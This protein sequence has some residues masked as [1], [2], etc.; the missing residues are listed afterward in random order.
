MAAQQDLAAQQEW[1]ASWTLV[2]GERDHH[3]RETPSALVS[4]GEKGQATQPHI[5]QV[6]HGSVLRCEG[7]RDLSAPTGSGFCCLN[8]AS[9]SQEVFAQ[10]RESVNRDLAAKNSGKLRV[11]NCQAGVV[12]GKFV[13][14]AYL[15]K[16]YPG[17]GQQARAMGAT[18]HGWTQACSSLGTSEGRTNPS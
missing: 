7:L 3:G 15:F 5:P 13:Y 2:E 18:M 14:K 10:L 11:Q 6:C 1:V 16:G 8:G 17:L 9:R 4:V 12:P